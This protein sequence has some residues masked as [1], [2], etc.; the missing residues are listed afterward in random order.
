MKS[1]YKISILCLSNIKVPI[2]ID[3]VLHSVIDALD[4][5]LLD[6]HLSDFTIIVALAHT[7][8]HIRRYFNG[9]NIDLLLRM[10]NCVFIAPLSKYH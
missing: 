6:L 4:L 2:H 8:T 1:I 5:G 9:A 3:L 7:I 10:L